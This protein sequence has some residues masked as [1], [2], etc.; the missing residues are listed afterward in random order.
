MP[1]ERVLLVCREKIG[2]IAKASR[3]AVVAS[4]QVSRFCKVHRYVTHHT[5]I[6]PH[7][8]RLERVSIRSDV[9]VATTSVMG[10]AFQIGSG[11]AA[12]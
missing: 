7:I 11:L 2:S 1:D 10:C 6:M 3:D 5:R 12:F 8:V 9:L 4:E